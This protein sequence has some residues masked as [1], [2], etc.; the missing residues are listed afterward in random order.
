VSNE[1]PG[2]ERHVE[3]SH[4]EELYASNYTRV[5][6]YAMRRTSKAEAED[7]TAA[8]FL[9]AWRR[10]NEI[11]GDPLPWLL[12]I[13]RRVLA[14][15]RRTHRRADALAIRVRH[16]RDLAPADEPIAQGRD[17]I[18]ATALASLRSHEREALLLTAWDE[19]ST[20][21]AAEVVGC[22]PGAF[23]VRLHRARKRFAGALADAEANAPA[24]TTSAKGV[25]PLP[26]TKG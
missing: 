17:H 18:V 5:F 4:F 19:L 15:E 8:T 12:G 1:W 7:V 3:S 24:P 23:R 9:V 10:R 22:S 16:S 6:A 21:Q 2:R 25:I 20:A 26:E 13:A 11:E 14:N